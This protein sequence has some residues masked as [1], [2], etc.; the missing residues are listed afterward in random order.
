MKKIYNKIT[1]N[2]IN[3]FI[4][5]L[6]LTI[7]SSLDLFKP[8]IIFGADNNFHLHRVLALSDNIKVGNIIPVYFKYLNG[9]GYG[10]GLFYPDLF[11]YIP[12]LLHCIGI[13]LTTSV[14]ILVF[15]INF[16]SIIFMYICMK[17]ITK[18][19]YA[20]II[21]SVLYAF[22]LYKFTDIYLRTALGESIVFIF[23]PLFILGIYE[24]FYGD[25]KKNY[26]LTIGLVGICYSHVISFYL[27]CF[28]L[29]VFIIINI[30]KLKEIKRLKSLTVN[31]VISILISSSFWLPFLEQ[32]ISDKFSFKYYSPVYESIVPIVALFMDFP[33]V[34]LFDAW[35]PPCIGICYFVVLYIF[36]RYKRDLIKKDKFLTTVFILGIVTMILSSSRILWKI[37]LFYDLFSIIQFPWRF[38]LFT[39][40]YF[41][42]GTSIFFSHYKNIKLIKLVI[43]YVVVIF[44]I[45]MIFLNYKLR[46]D[47]VFYSSEVMNGEYLPDNFDINTIN[48]YKN[49]N[50][51]YHRENEKTIINIKNKT[52]IIE[53]PLIYYKGYK[54]CD[55]EKCYKLQKSDNGLL[56]VN[57]DM[58]TNNL[59][60]WYEGTTLFKMSKYI[61]LFG[62]IL[63]VIYI[64]YKKRR[65][66]YSE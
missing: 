39:T 48:N 17:N 46:V 40:I 34:K 35:L 31:I 53:L 58:K 30:K 57:V 55:N 2:K 38:Y 63:F 27:T 16:L 32:Y 13:K 45:N 18:K 12:A 25:N 29:V 51:E 36:I 4:F 19:T 23:L 1:S 47:E 64:Y 52:E 54:A 3:L 28:F 41:I 20:S 15:F 50:I 22:S 11:L 44:S 8:G 9:F 5:F 24:I 65:N 33:I 56:E 26:F 42:V 37:D 61:S 59:T 14:K 21:G 10:N 7:L 62:L 43:T 6:I 60:V 66:E 49:E